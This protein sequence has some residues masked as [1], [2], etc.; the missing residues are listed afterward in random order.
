MKVFVTGGTGYV[1][2][3]IVQALVRAGHEVSALSRSEERD[4]TVKALGATPVRGSLG[5][6]APLAAR[7][8]EHDAV[9]HTAVDYGLGPPAGPAR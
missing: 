6:M 7:I 9:V 2:G 3:A 5:H 8:A 1:G 4:G